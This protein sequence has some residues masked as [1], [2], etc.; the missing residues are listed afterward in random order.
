MNEP[1]AQPAVTFEVEQAKRIG[2]ALHAGRLADAENIQSYM[3][4]ETDASGSAADRLARISTASMFF[5]QSVQASRAGDETKAKDLMD[6]ARYQVEDPKEWEALVA[7]VLVAA[8]R[9]DG[10]LSED[11][12]DLVHD[13]AAG[14]PATEALIAPIR[15]GHPTTD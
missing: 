3:L 10:W 9:R 14:N 1:T 7:G 8:G 13:I 5:M 2:E 4:A 6:A 11:Q 12:Y 15:R